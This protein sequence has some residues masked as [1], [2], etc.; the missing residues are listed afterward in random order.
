MDVT[1]AMKK[2]KTGSANVA[3]SY[4]GKLYQIESEA[5]D[6]DMGAEEVYELRQ[7]KAMPV[8]E[9]FKQWLDKRIQYTPPRGLLGKAIGYTVKRWDNLVRYLDDGRLRPDNN[10]A[11][12][13]IRPFVVGRKNWLF[14]GHPRG[15]EA[16]AAI[17]SLIETAKANG[18]E[19]YTYLRFLFEKLP[20][21]IT[22]EDY[23]ALLPQYLTRNSIALPV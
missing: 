22:K 9:E 11:E 3:L 4:I 18:I 17:Y 20:S 1:R 23:R 15:A 14:S 21:A 2:G 16:S 12:N 6:A 7:K 5:K 19:L 8:V 10:I 13:A